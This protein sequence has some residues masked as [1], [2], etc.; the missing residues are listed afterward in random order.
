[1]PSFE[2]KTDVL[3]S[4]VGEEKL[5]LGDL[6]NSL[7]DHGKDGWEL[8]TLVPNVNIQ[9]GKDGDLLIYKRAGS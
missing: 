4:I 8:A 2:Y 7:N 5:R 6:E 1:M 9:R 3:T